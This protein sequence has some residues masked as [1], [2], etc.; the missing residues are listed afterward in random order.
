MQGKCLA[1]LSYCGHVNESVTAYQAF[2]VASMEQ[3]SDRSETATI[4]SSISLLTEN[5]FKS[6]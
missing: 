3:A 4:N 2:S 6:V 1:V 5:I